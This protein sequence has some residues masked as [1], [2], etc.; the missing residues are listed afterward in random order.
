MQMLQEAAAHRE[1]QKR[2]S[3]N[4]FLPEKEKYNSVRHSVI[5]GESIDSRN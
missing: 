2:T 4:S 1:K 5:E 3:V